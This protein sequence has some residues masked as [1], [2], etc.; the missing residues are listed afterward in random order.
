MLSEEM[1]KDIETL[2]EVVTDDSSIA[3]LL[4]RK[5]NTK[6]SVL[7]VRR[8]RLAETAIAEQ[9]P[10]TPEETAIVVEEARA[11]LPVRV[12]TSLEEGSNSLLAAT[13]RWAFKHDKL[14]PNLTLQQ[15]RDRARAD[16]YSGPIE[17]WA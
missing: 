9:K 11:Q 12:G 10:E 4:Q 7:E 15:Q 2:I 16:G 1:K 13:C 3:K 8:H 5:Y 14:L 6:I 17:G